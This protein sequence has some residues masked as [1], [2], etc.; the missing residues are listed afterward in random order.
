MEGGGDVDWFE[1]ARDKY[2][3]WSVVITVMNPRDQLSA[4]NLLSS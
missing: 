4:G 2:K 1:L 3:R